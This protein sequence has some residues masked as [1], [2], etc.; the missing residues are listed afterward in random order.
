MYIRI[1]TFGLAGPTDEQYRSIATSIAD[2]FNDWP[3]LLAKVWIGDAA[4][5]RYGG[6]YLFQSATAAQASRSAPQ[7]VAMA[8]DPAFA[9]LTIEEFD[10][11]DEPS[12]TTAP[13][14][15]ALAANRAGV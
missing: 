11:L 9:N 13:Q 4:S 10:V 15:L 5:N 1:V 14:I 8:A 2:S 3:G 6:I 12:R 7:F